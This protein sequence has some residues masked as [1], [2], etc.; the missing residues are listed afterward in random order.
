MR[1][2]GI[3][4]AIANLADRIGGEPRRSEMALTQ[5]RLILAIIDQLAGERVHVA[6]DTLRGDFAEWY[7]PPAFQR[8]SGAA[9]ALLLTD[10]AKL[11]RALRAH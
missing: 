11:H 6:T 7:G 2:P 5:T 1:G 9:R 8:N 3:N 10:L 4:V